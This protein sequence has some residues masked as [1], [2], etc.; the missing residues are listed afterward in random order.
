MIIGSTVPSLRLFLVSTD[1]PQ[2]LVSADKQLSIGN[3]ER[4][5]HVFVGQPPQS[6]GEKS[7]A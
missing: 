5:V 3:G 2:V 4:G 7:P 6:G 1:A